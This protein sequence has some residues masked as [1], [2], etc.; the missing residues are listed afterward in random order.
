VASRIR[1]SASPNAAWR[2]DAAVSGPVGLAETNSTW[3]RSRLALDP[4]PNASPAA[5]TSSI[6]ARYQASVRNRLRKPGP[7]T[8]T[9]STR[10]PSRCSSAAPRRSATARGGS[11]SAG[12]SS[13]AAFVE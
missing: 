10:A 9:F 1:A 4:A 11:P 6:A 8:S 5:I 3:I 7:A 12:A 13:I 2:P